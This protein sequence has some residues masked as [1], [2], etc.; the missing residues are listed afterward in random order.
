V[1]IADTAMVLQQLAARRGLATE[2]ASPV[3]PNLPLTPTA[4]HR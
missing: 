3:L 2:L 4:E 1:A